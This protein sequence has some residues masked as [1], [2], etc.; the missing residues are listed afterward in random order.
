MKKLLAFAF[1]ILL[2]TGVAA[3]DEQGTNNNNSGDS[4]AMWLG[5][6]VAFGSM[7][8]MDLTIGPNF[9]LMIGE[10]IGVGGVLTFSSGNNAYAWGIEPYFRYYLPVADQFSFFGD[11]FVGF[12]G[13]DNQTDIDGGDYFDFSL[14]ARVGLQYWF[15]PKWSVAASNNVFIYNSNDGEIG[16]GLIFSSVNFSLFFHF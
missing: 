4:P 15:T 1:G 16:L 10:R 3:Q 12:G 14:G 6:Q 8:N 7:S 5:G 11:A 13:G 2:V 9:G